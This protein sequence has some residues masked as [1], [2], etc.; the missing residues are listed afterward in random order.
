MYK[1][2]KELQRVINT[3]KEKPVGSWGL[4]LYTKEVFFFFENGHFV[5]GQ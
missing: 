4:F 1:A 2:V 5:L 3:P